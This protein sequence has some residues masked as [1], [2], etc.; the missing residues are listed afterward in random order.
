MCGIVGY[1][2]T[3]KACPILLAGLS[4]LEYRGYDSA[5]IS[6]IEK[7]G[8]SL[9]KDKGRVKNLYNLE[10]I[11]ELEGTIGIAHTRWAT[12]GK[13]SKENAH[14][15][16]DNSKTFSV[17]H[18][19]IIEN[20]NELRKFLLEN[21][22]TFYSQTDTEIIPNLIHYYFYKD[23]EN[24]DLKFLRAVRNACLDLKGSF[25]LEVISKLYPDNM[26][27]VRKDSPLVIGTCED[28]KYLSSDIPAILSY[29]RDFYLLNDLEF[30]LLTKSSARFFDTDLKEL[31]K[32]TKTIEWNA[33]AAEKD[34]F[35]DFMLKEIYEQPSAIRETIGAK[36]NLDSTCEF[37]ELKFTKEYLSSLNKIYIVACGT[38][39]HAGLSGK[40]A[41]EKL[42]RIPVEVDI[43]SEFRYRDPIIDEK[44][45]CIFISQSGETADTIA[46]LKLS[47]EKGAKT[48]A[49]TNVIGSS[50]TREANYSIYTHAGPEIAVASTK[51]YTSQV[52]LINI[53][54]IYFAE[55][56]KT[57]TSEFINA[58]KKDILELPKKIEET[59]KTNEQIKKFA[60]QI[61]QEKDV[62]FLGRG[63]DETVAKEG[64]LKLKEIS[65]I[66][67]ESYAAGELKH[68]PIALI[69][70][71]ITVISIMTDPNLVKKTVSNIQEV[72]T[73][74]AKTLVI[75]NQNIDKNM[76]DVTIDI[77]ETNCFVSPILSIVPLQLLAYY[78]SKEKG[79]DVDKPRNLA[80]SVT[81][82]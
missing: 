31:E 49:I 59:L 13:P 47:K 6:T 41:I 62:F 29:T 14:P 1:I 67:S 75:S 74:G 61:Y 60:K 44:T 46:A 32:E 82:E 43:A 20:F 76:F 65:Y 39:M 55:I 15:H 22:Y 53:L 3:K 19:G 30:V 4:R 58:L 42:C 35:D 17:V 45:L 18:N 73:R 2:G 52:V 57:Q 78:I 51:A 8:L 27:V 24:D 16:Q 37:D 54:A 56:L 10:G 80:K 40:N 5:G 72:I 66:H 11:D 9:M 48:L 50:I 12:H 34:G 25:A 28:E 21:G 77:P 71:G 23:T 69:E 63:I 7:S 70:N 38:A 79:L 36:L 33:S 64:S 26:V 68:G 81:V